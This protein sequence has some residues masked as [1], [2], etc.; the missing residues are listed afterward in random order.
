MLVPALIA[1]SCSLIGSDD[2][3]A[4]DAAAED[5]ATAVAP[6]TTEPPPTTAERPPDGTGTFDDPRSIENGTF[7]YTTDFYD[8]D[9][10]GQLYGL[11]E[12]PLES[13]SDAVGT[14]FA[15]VGVMSPSRIGEGSI[16]E[17]YTAPSLG[18]VVDG[19]LVDDGFDC[20]TDPVSEV[21][22]GPLYDARVTV[23][24]DFAFFAAFLVEGDPASTPTALLLG[25]SD[26]GDIVYFTA[27]ILSSTP[28]PEVR[29]G[30]GAGDVEGLV[31]AR[32]SYRGEFDDVTWDAQ[33]FGIVD[34]E[35]ENYVDEPG[36]CLILV[37]QLTPTAID[38]GQLSDGFDTPDM[39]LLA[40]GVQIEDENDCDSEAI[41]AS[42]Y[43]RLYD[44]EVTVGTTY[45]FFAEYF[46]P[47]G[48]TAESV[49]VGDPTQDGGARFYSVDLIDAAP[50]VDI[51]A[52]PGT[53]PEGIT[54]VTGASFTY[55]DSF[56]E[57][58]WQVL[59]DGLVAIQVDEFYDDQVGRC[60]AVIGTITPTEIPE[61]SVTNGFD[62][63]DIGLIAA[64]R[65]VAWNSFYC[66]DE[67]LKANG[68]Q[69]L[70]NAE[71]PVG[72]VYPYFVTFFV[73]G[74]ASIR[75][76]SVFIGDSSE[77]DALYY[78]AA[79][80]DAVPSRN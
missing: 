71:I 29:T 19:V 1:A 33:L 25:D 43:G 76:D 21:G 14:C 6:A 8:T 13:Y 38:G 24:T 9:W 31:D 26:G 41:E 74:D 79:L 64:G 47:D 58:S 42:G 66:D 49:I 5:P 7:T 55:T 37:G 68:Y 35:K 20:D 4:I 78:D 32:F 51:S 11:V 72:T 27:D 61:S 40:N 77:P 70:T 46:I 18:L 57:T 75:L 17:G 65:A 60:F 28:I 36:S 63:P 3:N 12:I 59:I 10:A 53:L 80:L 54:P 52:S 73:P 30:A 15:V 23:G 22:Y 39:T 50:L 67:A 2:D 48:A 34:G 45:P 56:S 62:T 69:E 44:A 16:S